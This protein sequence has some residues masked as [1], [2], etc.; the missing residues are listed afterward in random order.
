MR[1]QRRKPRKA[2]PATRVEKLKEQVTWE[3]FKDLMQILSPFIL[4]FVTLWMHAHGWK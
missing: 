3:R 2:K 1:T 4:L